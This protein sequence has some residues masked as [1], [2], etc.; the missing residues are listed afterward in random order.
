MNDFDP[1]REAMLIRSP[2]PSTFI[3]WM[4]GFVP[5]IAIETNPKSS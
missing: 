2:G 3:L 4:I 5:F 1:E